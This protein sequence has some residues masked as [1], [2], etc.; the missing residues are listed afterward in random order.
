MHVCPECGLPFPTAD[1]LQVH[2]EIKHISKLGK[3]Q[4]DNERLIQRCDELERQRDYQYD[5]ANKYSRI[6]EDAVARAEGAESE[7]REILKALKSHCKDDFVVI[8]D[9]AINWAATVDE[10]T[11]FIRLDA[12]ENS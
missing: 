5:Q 11:N 7:V 4:R 12:S 10:F 9:G 6:G 2:E 3:L 1:G 8:T